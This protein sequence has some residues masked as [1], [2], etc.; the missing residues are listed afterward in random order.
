M[1]PVSGSQLLQILQRTLNHVDARLMG[2]GEKVAVLMRRILQTVPEMEEQECSRLCILGL[3]HDVGAYKTEE[4]SQLFRFEESGFRAHSAYGY[5]FLKIMSPLGDDAYPLLNHHLPYREYASVSPALTEFD[6][7]GLI[8]LADHAALFV[9]RGETAAGRRWILENKGTLLSPYWVERF[10]EAER[11]G[12]ILELL[13]GVNCESELES[14]VEGISI[15]DSDLRQY[16]SMIAY[17]IDFR[18]EYMVLHTVNTVSISRVMG[19]Y[20]GI[21]TAEREILHYGALLH[22][23]G[24]VACPVEILEKPGRLTPEEMEVMRQHVTVT[25]EILEGLIDPEVLE[26]ACRH[27]ERIDGSGYPQGLVYESLTLPQRI[28]GV[29]DVVSALIRRRSYKDAYDKDTTLQ[30]LTEMKQENRFCSTS[31][32]A[33]LEHFDEIIQTADFY[34]ATITEAYESIHLAYHELEN[35]FSGVS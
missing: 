34:G 15:S 3:L 29:A 19:E 8:F 30:I 33:V 13:E 11:Q 9:A 17:V 18:S 31:V 10:L 35:Q 24:K 32:N 25:R 1:L 21:P 2:H 16:L 20:I 22:D 26:I 28:L 5:L 27:H 14:L 4:I 12:G 7:A 23:I 6:Y